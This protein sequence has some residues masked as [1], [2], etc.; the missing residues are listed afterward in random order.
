MIFNINTSKISSQINPL[1]VYLQKQRENQKVAKLFEIGGTFLLISFFILFALKPTFFTIS[2]LVGDIK[3]KQLLSK[4]LKTKI[5]DVIAA[6]DLFSQAQE[7]YSLV[8]SSF[9]EK[10]RFFQATSQVLSSLQTHQINLDKI[11]Y[12]IKDQ[13]YF[14]TNIST[15][16]SY[17]SA[18]SFISDLLQNRRLMG[19]DTFTFSVSKSEQIQKIDIN[20]P[21][22]V[23]YW[24]N[25]TQK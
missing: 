25:D 21:L 1:F 11:D 16:S 22:K 2:S 19:L 8:E 9:P 10:P 3:S 5:N 12:L 7:R 15:S 24:Q 4:E 6:Q 23:Y 17:L 18:V 13:N 14:T 20:I